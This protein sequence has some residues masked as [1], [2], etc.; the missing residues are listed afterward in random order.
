MRAAPSRSRPSASAHAS[1]AA[2]VAC[3]QAEAAVAGGGDA[4][5][6]RRR[7][8]SGSH[9]RRRRSRPRRRLRPVRPSRH[10]AGRARARWWRRSTRAKPRP[11][12]QTLRR[13][14]RAAGAEPLDA[15][16][17]G[18][19]EA[20]HLG[21]RRVRGR[22]RRG[23]RCGLSAADIPWA[24]RTWLGSASPAAQAEP[25]G[26][27]IALAVE[28]EHEQV[29][30]DARR[31][32]RAGGPAAAARRPRPPSCGR[33]APASSRSRSAARPSRRAARR[34]RAPRRTRP[35]RARSRCPSAGRAPGPRPTPA[36]ASAP[37]CARPGSRPPWGRRACAPRARASRRPTAARRDRQRGR[38]LHG[39]AVQRHA[40]LG[41]GRGQPRDRL[42]GPGDVVRPHHRGQPVAGRKQPLELVGID[43]PVARRP[44]P[45]RP[46]T[47]A[48]R[49]RRPARAR[50]GARS[51][52]RPPA[53]A[54]APARPNTAWLSA[55]EPP[56]VKTTWPGSASSSSAEPAARVLER[57][58]GGAA[59]A[60]R[61]RGVAEPLRQVRLHRRAG[62]GAERRRR[63]VVEIHASRQ[64]HRGQTVVE[65]EQCRGQSPSQTMNADALRL[66]G[67]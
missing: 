47:R 1:S 21:R 36:A 16:D 7:A 43:D 12:R 62:L 13:S 58:A 37:A 15:P 27:G 61:L 9:R 44:A 28:R 66:G 29:G 59:V 50:P 14:P 2:A 65:M 49:A 56:E 26:D 18:R 48:A 19:G 25:G 31:P 38:R 40:P 35:L 51:R 5:A 67:L 54:G 55:S 30:A 39:V 8:R 6:A 42:H 10:G 3:G 17:E 23:R 53:R 24:I 45:S 34:P 20:V 46:R 22:A 32:A 57:G 60:V 64:H 63:R 52:S 11:R 41:R 33:R 4:A